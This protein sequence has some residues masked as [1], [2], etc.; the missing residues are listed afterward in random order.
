MPRLNSINYSLKGL[1]LSPLLVCFLAGVVY[2]LPYY[3]DFLFFLSFVALT[4]FFI[5]LLSSDG[6]KRFFRYSYTFFLGFYFSLY[7]WLGR[8]YP[9]AGFDFTPF[10]GAM[11]IAFA[12]VGIPLFHALLHSLIML[13]TKLLPD[14]K[15]TLA[16]GFGAAWIL[17]EWIMSLGALAFPWGTV[18]LSQTGFLLSVQTVSL[19]GSYFIIIV[20]V[21]SSM[22]FALAVRN[23]KSMPAVL[24]CIIIA[25]NLITGTI[26]YNIPINRN[27]SINTAILQGNAASGEKWEPGNLQRIWDNYFSMATQAAENGAE[28]IVLPESAIPTSFYENGDLHKSF[29]RITQEYNVTITAGVAARDSEGS[30]NSVIAVYPDGSLSQR[31]D[32]RHLVP[33]GEYIPFQSF[34]ETV[35][36]FVTGLNLSGMDTVQGEDSAVFFTLG[37]KN[38]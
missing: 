37:L 29:A 34:L 32:K 19:F 26:L 4:V 35:F 9:F 33:F 11:I 38:G 36:P 30:Y 18:A 22:L 21:C 10:Q 17:A 6:R 20:V 7:L 23:R 28:L 13:L 15:W 5:A 2:S 16:A 31:Y 14:N 1:K 25:A 24:G 3:F 8:L 12:C 27:D